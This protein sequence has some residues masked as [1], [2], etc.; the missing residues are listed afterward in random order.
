M[1]AAKSQEE[2]EGSDDR[3][4]G[5]AAGAPAGATKHPPPPGYGLLAPYPVGAWLVWADYSR[6]IRDLPDLRWNPGRSQGRGRRRIV[7]RSRSL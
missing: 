3:V 1:A 4:V 6:K 2:V 7:V 5:A